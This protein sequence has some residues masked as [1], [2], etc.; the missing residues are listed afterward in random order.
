[1]P[2]IHGR[3]CYHPCETFCNRAEVDEAVSIHAVERFLGDEALEKGWPI[4]EPA[5]LTHKRVLI[6]GAGP[7]GLATAYYL[8]LAGHDVEIHENGPMAGGMM[9]FGIPTYRLPRPILEGEIRRIE[10]MPI[11]I[12]T[13]MLCHQIITLVA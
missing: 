7:C 9:R 1:M 4:P 8:G 2:A 10:N 3:V 6:I 13:N 5:P 12:A 11:K